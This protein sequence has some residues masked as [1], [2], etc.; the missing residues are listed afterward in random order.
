MNN[1]IIHTYYE[2]ID[3]NPK[4]LKSEIPVIEFIKFL[5][6]YISLPFAFII[7]TVTG[8][9]K[10]RQLISKKEITLGRENNKLAIHFKENKEFIFP[11]GQVIKTISTYYSR[12]ESRQVLTSLL[13]MGFLINLNDFSEN[14]SIKKREE[15]VLSDSDPKTTVIIT[16][17]KIALT[18]NNLFKKIKL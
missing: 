5:I 8:T 13:K 2:I 3:S 10:I 14:Y 16:Y 6:Y 12:K 4:I 11:D 15:T 7:Y 18:I 1:N 17:P 9:L